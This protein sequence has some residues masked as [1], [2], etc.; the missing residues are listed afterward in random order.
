[1]TC[2]VVITYGDGTTRHRPFSNP[3]R[4]IAWMDFM[5]NRPNVVAADFSKAPVQSGAWRARRVLEEL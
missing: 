1:M 4:A 2:T 5:A 3:H